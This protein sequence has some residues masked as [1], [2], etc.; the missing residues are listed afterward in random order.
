MH[1]ITIVYDTYCGWCYGAEPV[2]SALVESGAPVRLL[3]RALFT[4]RNR[5]RMADFGAIAWQHDQRIAALSGQTFSDD[6]RR[7]VLEAPGEVLDSWPTALAAAAVAEQGP[8]AELAL[9]RR[10]QHA[11]YVDGRPAAD[12]ADVEAAL[13]EAGLGAAAA[14]SA[15]SGDA[16]VQDAALSRQRQAAALLRRTGA[17]AVPA[18]VVH[19][20]GADRRVDLGP[21][22][23][24]PDALVRDLA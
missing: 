15:L 23:G 16:T 1:P 19:A 6:Y 18:L 13:R 20:D 10:L 17:D 5:P 7:Q 3:H 11:R 9:A 12:L 14:R 4:G 8:A 21:Y 22:L 24:R 2:L